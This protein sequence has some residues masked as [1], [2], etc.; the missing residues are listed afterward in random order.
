[1]KKNPR[2]IWVPSSE[3]SK[4][5]KPILLQ[6][7]HKQFTISPSKIWMRFNAYTSENRRPKIMT[8][9]LTVGENACP[10]EIETENGTE[11]S[12]ARKSV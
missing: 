10:D 5:L 7:L 6:A 11:L 1:M 2:H 8:R 12:R 9:F 4:L 3:Y